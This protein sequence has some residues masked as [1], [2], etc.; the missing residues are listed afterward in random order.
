MSANILFGGVNFTIEG[1]GGPDCVS[2]L[3]ESHRFI[4]SLAFISI[5]GAILVWAARKVSLPQKEI[6]KVKTQ[7]AEQI[8]FVTLLTVF[9]L[10]V[11]YKMLSRQLLW[12]LNPCHML[13]LLQ[14]LLLSFPSS[15]ASLV[16]FRLHLYWLTGPVLAILFPVTWTREMPGEVANYWFQHILI[17]LV[18]GYLMTR[19]SYASMFREQEN[20]ENRNYKLDYHSDNRDLG[21][22]SSI[23]SVSAWP[24]LSY[25]V[26][27]LYHWLFLQSIGL[28]T[29]VNLNNMLCPAASDPFYSA[30][31]RTLAS[32][33]LAVL[34]PG[35][36]ELY[37]RCVT[38]FDHKRK[39]D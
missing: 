4:E 24:L 26:F 34:G 33:Y 10:E 39:Q 38:R 28:I 23:P 3:S 1:E 13:T 36:G 6:S 9:L 30:Q 37:I 17:L 5:N 25:S 35:L 12:L 27:S 2:F 18:P 32:L 22:G 8:L 20:D 31:Y 16:M 15:P 7:T 11:S 19:G 14:L 21:G 29:Q